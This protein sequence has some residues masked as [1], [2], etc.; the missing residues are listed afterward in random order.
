MS[1]TIV[2][3]AV[4]ITRYRILAKE[5]PAATARPVANHSSASALPYASF[6]AVRSLGS[7]VESVVVV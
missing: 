5:Q 4:P 7:R 1:S 3:I 2:R 6:V